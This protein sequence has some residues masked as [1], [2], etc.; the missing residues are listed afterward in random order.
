MWAAAWGVWT[1]AKPFRTI[2]LRG[3]HHAYYQEEIA[4]HPEHADWLMKLFSVARH[5]ERL[6]DMTT[7]IAEEV[8]YM[9]DGAIVRHRVGA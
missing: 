7:H 9:V 8:I 6:A 5:L 2:Q 3:W 4:K 1:Q